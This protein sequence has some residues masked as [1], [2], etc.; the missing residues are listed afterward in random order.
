MSH[1]GVSRPGAIR[2]ELMIAACAAIGGSALTTVLLMGVGSAYA[3]GPTPS[4]QTL[5]D[6]VRKL[7]TRVA[8]DEQDRDT[9]AGKNI[10]NRVRAPFVSSMPRIGR[11]SPSMP[12]ATRIC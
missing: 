7:E 10:A 5:H 8:A 6:R 3:V 4:L 12:A 1:S 2:R 11:S 9:P